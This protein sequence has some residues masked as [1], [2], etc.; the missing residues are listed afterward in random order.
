MNL[1]HKRHYLPHTFQEADYVESWIA[2]VWSEIWT[3]ENVVGKVFPRE[4][5]GDRGITVA[6]VSEVALELFCGRS[7]PGI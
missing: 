1:A 2:G 4:D 5:Q 6:V 7:P 3:R